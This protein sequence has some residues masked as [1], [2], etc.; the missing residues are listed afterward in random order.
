MSLVFWHFRVNPW[1]NE[2]VPHR[3]PYNDVADRMVTWQAD[4]AGDVAGD[5]ASGW[6]GPMVG[7]HVTVGKFPMRARNQISKKKM[8]PPNLA[9]KL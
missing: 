7:C 9:A 4:V 1:T 2:K 5:Y 3:S 6:R 8:G